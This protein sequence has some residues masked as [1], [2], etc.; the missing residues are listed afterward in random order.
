MWLFGQLD[1]LGEGT[2]KGKVD[3]E[4]R[5]VADLLGKV[6]G[7][8]HVGG[9]VEV[10]GNGSGNGTQQLHDESHTN[11]DAKGEDAKGDGKMEIENA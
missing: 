11:G 4:A 2:V 7:A 3:E 6:V 1:T 10:N 8:E 9:E 5:A